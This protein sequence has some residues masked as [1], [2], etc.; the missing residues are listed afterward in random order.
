M[1]IENDSAKRDASHVVCCCAYCNASLANL[2]DTLSRHQ[3]VCHTF[4][5]PCIGSHVLF[6]AA[7][8]APFDIVRLSSRATMWAQNCAIKLFFTGTVIILQFFQDIELINVFHVIASQTIWTNDR[9]ISRI[10]MENFD[11]RAWEKCVTGE[12]NAI[13][14]WTGAA[15]TAAETM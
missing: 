1:I 14:N 3:L 5:C 9:T 11:E 7:C 8:S 15:S 6:G 4:G 13:A 12:G 2:S 10:A